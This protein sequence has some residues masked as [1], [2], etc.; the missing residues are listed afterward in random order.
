MWPVKVMARTTVPDGVGSERLTMKIGFSAFVCAVL[1]IGMPLSETTG[2]EPPSMIFRSAPPPAPTT[3][4]EAQAFAVDRFAQARENL[5]AL[6]DG[7]LAV[8]D[9]TPQELQDVLDLDRMLRG[10]A[11]EVPSP[12]QQCVDDEVRRA[13]GQPSRLA[14]RVIAL[15]CR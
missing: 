6:R 5:A 7:R 15:K 11:A 14:W 10:Y 2:A 3:S 8:S 4:P 13:G 1:L 12:R 9:L